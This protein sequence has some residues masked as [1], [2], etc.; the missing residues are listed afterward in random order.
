MVLFIR[1]RKLDQSRSWQAADS[2]SLPKRG[3][4]DSFILSVSVQRSAA[5]I[6]G[7][8]SHLTG[9]LPPRC[10]QSHTAISLRVLLKS[11]CHQKQTAGW[12]TYSS[13]ERRI[14]HFL[15][16]FIRNINQMSGIST[17]NSF[18]KWK[19]FPLNASYITLKRNLHLFNVILTCCLLLQLKDALFLL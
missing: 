11:Q 18:Q 15:C 2:S 14:H 6:D 12:E 17:V 1:R 9:R 8:M 13:L 4:V 7:A 5:Q 16:F 3:A 10:T 19:T